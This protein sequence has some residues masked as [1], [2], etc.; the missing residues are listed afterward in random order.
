[1]KELHELI[2]ILTKKNDELCDN[3]KDYVKL[4]R[5]YS[6]YIRENYPDVHEEAVK[7]NENER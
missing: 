1:M 5:A 7:E 4:V 2:D 6:T 3:V